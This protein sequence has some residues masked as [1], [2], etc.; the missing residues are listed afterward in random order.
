MK[1]S[2]TGT[3]P[4]GQSSKILDNPLGWST[5]SAEELEKMNIKGSYNDGFPS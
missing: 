5:L 4:F 3:N 2:S 1:I